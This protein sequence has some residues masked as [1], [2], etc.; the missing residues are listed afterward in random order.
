M[1]LRDDQIRR[2]ARQLVMRDFTGAAQ[3]C[4][5]KSRVLVYGEGPPMDLCVLYLAAAGV[6]DIHLSGVRPSVLDLIWRAAA[7]NPDC[8]VHEGGRGLRPDY[9]IDFAQD[10][11][12]GAARRAAGALR[13]GLPYLKVLRAAGAAIMKRWREGDPCPGCVLNAAGLKQTDLLNPGET[14]VSGPAAA[15][16]A[17]LELA[18]LGVPTHNALLMDA[19]KGAY[20]ELAATPLPE[21]IMCA[22]L[23]DGR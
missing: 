15:A 9:V 13:A 5:L 8:R 18:G 12:P 14:S 10:A 21:C 1:P 6:G 3:E 22:E 20:R 11:G 7:L 4:L 2:Y 17:T 19:D 16:F 23:A